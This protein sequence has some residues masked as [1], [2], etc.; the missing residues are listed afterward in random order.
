MTSEQKL[1]RLVGGAIAQYSMIRKDDRILLAF[2]GGKDSYTLLDI[3]LRLQK[4]API[5]FELFVVM[6]DS[7]FGQD[8][9]RAEKYLKAQK[10]GYLIKKTNIAEIVRK[11][12][13]KKDTGKYCS[14]CSRLR[15]GALYSL[16]RE[17]RCNRLALGH[18]LDD[19][20]ETFLL[21][22]FYVS[23]L[24]PLRPI[25]LAEDKKTTIIRPLINA[26]EELI[27]K[28]AKERRFP[29]IRQ[30]CLFKKQ[31]SKR[32]KLKKLIKGLSNENRLLHSS[33]SNALGKLTSPIKR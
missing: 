9:S 33:I 29:I 13:T 20:I 15:R 18:N 10:V 30:K 2:S 5:H 23:R 8:Y 22:L 24:S 14:L 16:A 1:A 27:R 21:N 26:P 19:A 3:L 31:D 6:V 12:I 28:Y 17:H 4:K 7:G 32:A 25:Y 11:K